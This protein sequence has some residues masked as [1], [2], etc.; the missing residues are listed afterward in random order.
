M[1]HTRSDISYAVK[2]VSKPIY[3]KKKKKLN[4]EIF[5]KRGT[6][7]KLVRYCDADC[8]GDHDTIRLTT[9]MSSAPQME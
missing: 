5:Y 2:L 7:C 1:T 9:N 6:D 3:I 4:Y 8:V